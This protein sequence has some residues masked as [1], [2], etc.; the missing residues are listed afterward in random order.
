[1]GE[2]KEIELET[3][4]AD[5]IAC[6]VWSPVHED[7]LLVGSWDSSIR[8]YDAQANQQRAKFDHKAAVLGAC[9]SPKADQ[10]FSGGLDTW[11]RMWD[12]QSG[13][14]RVLGTHSRPIS[15]VLYSTETNTIVTGSW[16]STV[17][18]HDPRAQEAKVASYNQP[19]RVY[20]MDAVGHTLVVAMGGR[21]ISV[22]DIRNMGKPTQERESSL[23]FMTRALACMPS[24]E[25]F[26]LAS[27]EGRVAVEYFDMSPAIQ[28]KKYA[29]KCHRQTVDGMDH[30]WPVNALAFH[31]VHHTLASCGSDGIVAIWDHT[32]KKRLRQ[33]PSYHSAVNA[34]AFNKTGSKLA[35]GVSY[36]W[37]KG[38]EGARQPES[39]RVSIYVREIGKEVVPKSKA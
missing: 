5:G 29:F 8:L 10:V 24:G 28:A 11:L 12:I 37:D 2:G 19:E 39:S 14:F 15:S 32:T 16:D 33:F 18:I 34:V 20:H 30:V 13:E 35:I 3:V 9:F 7:H 26:A 36:G 31:P 22:Y 17:A 21:Q 4:P 1:M 38:Q 25:G 23:R 6:L 27:I